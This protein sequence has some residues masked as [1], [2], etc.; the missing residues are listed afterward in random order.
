MD[1]KEVVRYKDV[2][3]KVSD[4]DVLRGPCFL[5]DQIIAFYFSYLY[6]FYDSCTDDVLLVP[7][8]VSFW[9]ANSEEDRENL[10]DFLEPLKLS[11]KRLVLFTVND[12]TDFG[13]SEA[14]TH[15]SLLFMTG[16]RIAFHIMIAWRELTI[17]TPE[18]L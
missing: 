14:G 11:T 7:P 17:F 2:V 16:P 4:L 6:A 12:S 10:I 15:W 5:N 8:S 1:D 13:G 3:L 18:A 9:L